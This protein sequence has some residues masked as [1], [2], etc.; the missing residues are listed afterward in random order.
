VSRVLLTGCLGVVG[1]PLQAELERRGHETWGCDLVHSGKPRYRRCDVGDF[2]VLAEIVAET[3][4]EYVYHLAGEFGRRNGEDHYESLWHTNAV[5]TKNVL[6]LQATAGF[7]AV[8]FSSSEIYGDQQETLTEDLPQRIPL[9]QLNDYAISKWV[10]ELQVMNAADTQGAESVR[11]RL[12]N[13]Y[14]PGEYFHPYRS[15]VCQFVYKA[16]HDLPYE[17]F[18]SHTR[19]LTYIDDAIAALAA[20]VDAF[21]PGAVYNIASSKSHSMRDLSELVLKLT[22]RT[23]RL[24]RYSSV[25]SHNALHK[26]A[27]NSMA[28]RDLDFKE[29]VDLAEGV[30]R[31]VTWQSALYKQR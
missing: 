30:S 29:T 24:V 31:T 18:T 12:F 14:G 8:Y 13:T 5:G 6:R 11:V 15:V 4:P 7:R 25:E 27:D 3:K 28:V 9:R 21:K 17:V 16:L 19:S 22:S 20:I 23:D 26:R 1:A 2:R 10:N